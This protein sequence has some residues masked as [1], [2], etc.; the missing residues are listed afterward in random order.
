MIS[1]S[2]PEDLPSEVLRVTT[3]AMYK[4]LSISSMEIDAAGLNERF[5]K[6]PKCNY[7][8]QSVYSD[9]TGHMNIK[10]PKCKRIFAINLAY[11]RTAKRYF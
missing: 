11:F 9:C 10:C 5:I 2:L 1:E 7:K 8:V 4:Y 3:E 6:C